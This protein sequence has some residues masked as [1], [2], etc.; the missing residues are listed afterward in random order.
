MICKQLAVTAPQ[1]CAFPIL[2]A[3]VLY[4]SGP[5]ARSGYLSTKWLHYNYYNNI[6]N[7]SRCA[8]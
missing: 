3:A 8:K 6:G 4:D 2:H 5:G 1:N 7:D